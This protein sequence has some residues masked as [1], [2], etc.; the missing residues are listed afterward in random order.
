MVRIPVVTHTKIFDDLHL[1][2]TMGQHKIVC[3]NPQA[4]NVNEHFEHLSNESR[5]LTRMKNRHCIVF[6]F[7]AVIS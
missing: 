3:S 7:P 5:I 1:Q 4:N 6:K 2:S